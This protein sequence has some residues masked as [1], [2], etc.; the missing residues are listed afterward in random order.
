MKKSYIYLISTFI[1][2]LIDQLIKYLVKSFGNFDL[3]RN[4]ITITYT[5][6]TGGAFSIGIGKI[7]VFIVASIII[8]IAVLYIKKFIYKDNSIGFSFILAGGIGNLIDRMFRGFVIDYID[9]TKIIDF[10]VFN[11]ADI[12]IVIGAVI[13]L[14]QVLKRKEE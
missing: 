6:N 1:L 2:V 10:P 14:T 11:L 8:I 13:F 4:I 12:L 3:V 9:I 7:S 5:E